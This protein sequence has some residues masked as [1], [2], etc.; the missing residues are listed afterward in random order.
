MSPR[1]RIVL[2]SR[3]LVRQPFPELFAARKVGT[4]IEVAITSSG[5]QRWAKER[6]IDVAAHSEHK[7][8]VER[9]SAEVL[10]SGAVTMPFRGTECLAESHNHHGPVDRYG[11]VWDRVLYLDDARGVVATF[12]ICGEGRFRDSEAVWQRVMDSFSW[13][14][15]RA[16]VLKYDGDHVAFRKRFLKE[17]DEPGEAAGSSAASGGRELPSTGC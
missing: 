11:F 13:D 16:A 8:L 12:R 5:V 1:A 10:R 6:Q 14:R 3:L 2:P 7:A 17:E 9:L 4:W 15:Q